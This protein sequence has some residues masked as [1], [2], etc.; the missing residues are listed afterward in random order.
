MCLEACETFLTHAKYTGWFYVLILFKNRL[1]CIEKSYN[2]K[3]LCSVEGKFWLGPRIWGCD[4]FQIRA[5]ILNYQVI[6]L[7]LSCNYVEIILWLSYNYLAIILQLS[8]DYL[9]I[10][11]RL[12]CD[13]LT[14]IL[15]SSCTYLFSCSC[16]VEQ[17]DYLKV[18]TK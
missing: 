1:H 11:L 15:L 18:I 2:H 8:C 17:K 14:I 10:I 7:C 4:V 6:I 9:A 12:S 3:N 5:S 13:Y 16:Y